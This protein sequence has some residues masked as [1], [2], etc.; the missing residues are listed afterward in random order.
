MTIIATEPAGEDPTLEDQSEHDAAVSQGAAEV[1]ADQAADAAAQ[2][3]AAAAMADA[4]AEAN[5]ATAEDAAAAAAQAGQSAATAGALTDAI[6]AA[7]EGQT[8]AINSLVEEMRANRTAPPAP[9]KRSRKDRSPAPEGGN[10][11]SHWYYR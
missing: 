3:E 1:H 6:A 7:L 4:A 11:R 2:A 10:Q 5:L 9:P 8:A